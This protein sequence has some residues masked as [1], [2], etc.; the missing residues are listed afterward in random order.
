MPFRGN[1]IRE[2]TKPFELRLKNRIRDKS[3]GGSDVFRKTLSYTISV[4]RKARTFHFRSDLLS[5]HL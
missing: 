2:R 3:P 4:L 1:G 5:M